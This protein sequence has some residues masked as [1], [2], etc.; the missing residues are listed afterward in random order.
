MNCPI[1][2]RESIW[3]RHHV[4]DYEITYGAASRL[5]NKTFVAE[6][7][8]IEGFVNPAIGDEVLVL[9]GWVFLD[10]KRI[11]KLLLLK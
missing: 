1:C 2:D 7:V 5:L 3:C 4:A 9:D 8:R 6:L 11:D 10:E